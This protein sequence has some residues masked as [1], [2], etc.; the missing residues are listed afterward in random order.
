MRSIDSEMAAEDPMAM[1]IMRSEFAPRPDMDSDVYYEPEDDE[2]PLRIFQR[3][4]PAMLRNES[5]ALHQFIAGTASGKVK[6]NFAT[7]AFC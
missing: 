5:S 7:N 1:R 6:A 4:T 2:C 3:D